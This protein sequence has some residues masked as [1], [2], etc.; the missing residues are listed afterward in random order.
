MADIRDIIQAVQ[1]GDRAQARRDLLTLLKTN[2]RD[3]RAWYLMSIVVD[4]PQQKRDCLQ[5]VLQI[6]PNNA[7]AQKQLAKLAPASS[8][9]PAAPPPPAKAVTPAPPPAA[10]PPVTPAAE[11]EPE[12]ADDTWVAKGT[13]MF[14]F[15]WEV[16]TPP[17]TPEEWR[18]EEPELATPTEHPARGIPHPEQLAGWEQPAQPEPAS[19]D[20]LPWQRTVAPTGDD[21]LPGDNINYDLLADA[22]EEDELMPWQRTVTPTGDDSLPG[23]NINY[24]LLADADEED[25]LMPW[26]QPVA[27]TGDDSLPGDNINYDLLA[28]EDDD[29]ILPWQRTVTPTGD[30]SL[31]GE[32]INYDLLADADE[33]DELM[34]WEQPVAPTGDDS[35]PGSNINYDLLQQRDEDDIFAWE[36]SANPDAPEAFAWSPDDEDE[37]DGPEALFP[38]QKTTVPIPDDT[39]TGNAPA[40]WAEIE[41]TEPPDGEAFDFGATFSAT[42]ELT[43]FDTDAESQSIES[44]FRWDTTADEP[45]E[46]TAGYNPYAA[47]PADAFDTGRLSAATFDWSPDDDEPLL[48]P[49]DTDTD[50]PFSFLGESAT[51]APSEREDDPFGFLTTDDEPSQW[52][53][54]LNATP[55]WVQFAESSAAESSTDL[56]AA[57]TDAMGAFGTADDDE[58]NPFAFLSSGTPATTDEPTFDWGASDTDSQDAFT[59]PPTDPFSTSADPFASVADDSPFGAAIPDPFA[60]TPDPFASTPDPF[61]ETADDDLFGDSS[62]DDPFANLDP[63]TSPFNWQPPERRPKDTGFLLADVGLTADPFDPEKA[64]DTSIIPPPNVDAEFDLQSLASETPDWLPDTPAPPATSTPAFFTPT[65]AGFDSLRAAASQDEDIPTLETPDWAKG[66]GDDPFGYELPDIGSDL[67]PF[68]LPDDETIG[69]PPN[70]DLS[71]L[72]ADDN[73][74]FD[75][76]DE[77]NDDEDDEKPT[78]LARFLPFLRRKKKKSDT[79]IEAPVGSA[80]AEAEVQSRLAMLSGTSVA[81]AAPDPEELNERRRQRA[82]RRRQRQQARRLRLI[83]VPLT[84]VLLVAICGG[85]GYGLLSGLIPLPGPVRS[86]A[87]GV[88]LL[89]SPTWDP[90]IPTPTP[91]PTPAPTAT[92]TATATLPPSATLPPT[93]TPTIP[94]TPTQPPTPFFAAGLPIDPARFLA[95]RILFLDRGVLKALPLSTSLLSTPDIGLTVVAV[96]AQNQTFIINQLDYSV[97]TRQWL[98]SATTPDGTIIYLLDPGATGPAPTPVLTEAPPPDDSTEP[99]RDDLLVPLLIFGENTRGRYYEPA[100]SPDGTQFAMSIEE[101]NGFRHIYVANIDGSNFRPLTSGAYDNEYPTWSPD[102]SQLVF[103]SDR[104]GTWDLYRMDAVTGETAD[105]AAER[106]TFDDNADERQPAWSPDGRTI[107]FVSNASGQPQVTLLDPVTFGTV[108]VTSGRSSNENPSWSPDSALILFTSTRD[109]NAELYVITPDGKD[110]RRLT[111]TALTVESFPRWQP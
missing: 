73:A 51:S 20:V 85:V 3:E 53:T 37:A 45:A 86:V 29:D 13:S 21:S 97:V 92:A 42:D 76:D 1:R 34:P 74:R 57:Q 58:D 18:G 10:K 31:P 110:L 8:T 22:D 68:E 32:K 87:E 83:L 4:D 16:P 7:D 63:G 101:P 35:L 6:N 99:I 11:P 98:I 15:P 27:P 88:G 77:A 84:I 5:R 91:T 47:E 75:P 65:N 96:A 102:G 54:Q 111:A 26:E 93:I 2:S 39:T 109:G 71:K 80:E 23:D 46:D 61:A 107:A 49:P 41:T 60:S 82:E 78:G 62:D 81:E 48:T 24:D 66:D 72:G 12:P 36:Q 25:E 79:D 64:V 105:A 28:E 67:P 89:P 69:I 44:G 33:E 30:D 108:A 106:I 55:D 94:A 14:Q 17:A 70:I 56:F 19:D 40:G 90:S 50:A 43:T 100:W 59:R 95:G 104:E 103:S 38:W 52:D 9:P